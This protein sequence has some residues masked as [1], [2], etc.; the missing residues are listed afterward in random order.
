M[1]LF[2]FARDVGRRIFDTDAEAADNIEEMI[3]MKSTPV[4]NLDVDFDDGTVTL[5]GECH[6]QA[7]REQIILMT[8]NVKGVEKVVAD[9]LT[10]PAP[11]PP[12]PEAPA[13]AEEKVEFYE[14]KRG[15]SLSLIAKHYYGDP[16]QYPRIYEANRAVIGDDPDK[17]FPGQKIRVPLD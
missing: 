13:A 5:C 14:I 15:D 11:P 17:I 6:S 7:D 16:M 2:D 12:S 8:G 4:K 3:Q 10:A 1:G 9:K